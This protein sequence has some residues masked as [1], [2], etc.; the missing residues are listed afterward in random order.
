MKAA[1][2]IG[3]R[4]YAVGIRLASIASSKASKWITGRR[5]LFDQLEQH[6]DPEQNWIWVHA[7]SLGEFEQ[8][9]PV[10]DRLRKEHA[11]CKILLTFFSP[12]GYDVRKNYNGADFV[13]YMPL[14]TRSNARKFVTAVKP[15]LA[16]FV[17]YELWYHHLKA[18]EEHGVPVLLISAQFRAKQFYFKTI[19][20]FFLPVLREL[21]QIFV[22]DD[23][24]AQVLESNGFDNAQIAG[25]TRI[26]RVT[27]IAS[28]Q[29][30]HSALRAILGGEKV[31]VAGSTWPE[32]EKI[33]IPYINANAIK[34]VIAPHDIAEHRL[35]EIESRVTG[36]ALRISCISD[37]DLTDIQVIIVDTMGQL[38]HLYGLATITYVGGGFGSGI[39]NILEAAAYGV[40]ILFG[41]NYQRFGEAHALIGAGVGFPVRDRETLASTLDQLDSPGHLGTISKAAQE[42]FARHRGATDLIYDYI[43]RERLLTDEPS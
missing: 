16:V 18:L 11:D 37:S 22:T 12:S 35:R 24:S 20:R 5:N 1:Y 26:D 31:L 8:G 27:Q 19:G 29:H 30:D 28:E 14:D 6:V 13:T 38:A 2:S 40:P 25:D 7:A 34:C 42:Y 41:P 39:H 15:K 3:I 9:R 32:D 17:K 4:L 36:N 10:I 23:A 21:K 43:C 33:L